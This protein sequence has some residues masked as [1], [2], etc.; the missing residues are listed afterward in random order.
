MTHVT[1]TVLIADPDPSARAFLATQVGPLELRVLEAGDGDT[2]LRILASEDVKL[3]VT[4]LYLP[5][6]GQRCLI[7]AARLHASESQLPIVAHTHRS[8]DEDR[9]WAMESGASAYLIKPTR[10]PRMRYVVGRLLVTPPVAATPA[11]AGPLMRRDSLND[12]LNDI[13]DGHLSESSCIIFG[14][15][16]WQSLSS[17]ERMSYRSRAKAVRVSLR[18][19]SQMANHYVEVRGKYRSDLSLSSEQ[20]E[21]PYRR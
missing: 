3:L 14:R 16:W 20:P 1:R 9:S 11:A 13:E 6:N 4:E 18:S 17:G 15:K 5:A 12:A 21:S 10:T 19:D 7:S 2:A 8:L